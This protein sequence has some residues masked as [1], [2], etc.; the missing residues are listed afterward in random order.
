M[1]GNILITGI[2][3]FVGSHLA[4]FLLKKNTHRLHGTRRHFRSNIENISHI[5]DAIV[6]HECDLK[7]LGSIHRVVSE[8]KPE[9]IFHL[10]AQSFVGDSYK[11]P[12]ETLF[13][14]I[15]GA[16]NILEAVRMERERDKNYDPVIHIA[17]SSEE[18]GLV[19][20]DETPITETNILRPQSP[21]GVS[22]IA[23][24]H[25]A[26]SYWRTY[27]IR[28]ITTRAFNHTGPRRGEIFATSAF[29]KQVAEIE[30]GTKKDGII[31]HGNLNAQRDF[32]D[33]RDMAL[34]YWL[35]ATMCDPG[36]I[37]NIAS[38]TAHTIRL[39]LE[40][41]VRQSSA[42]ITIREDPALLRPSDV[43]ILLGDAAKFREKTGW[44]PTIPFEQTLRDLLNYWREKVKRHS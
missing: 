2:N 14:N 5:L 41:F 6:L 34:A 27:G 24:T 13:N 8:V 40:F 43:P 1:S 4:E 23:Q 42:K 36:E 28:A 15:G 22:K 21:Y 35:A 17:G 20:P 9:I 12:G 33:V 37:Y 39:V 3:G 26:G 11:S 18:Y 19:L 30:H 29:A 7:D 31:Y 10:A 25:L 44:Q 32:T 16:L 38:G